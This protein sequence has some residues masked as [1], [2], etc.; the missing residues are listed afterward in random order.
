MSIEARRI[1]DD[2]IESFINVK[3]DAF[4]GSFGGHVEDER[5]LLEG[6][7]M[8]AAY[9][10]DRMV[11]AAGAFD[12]TVRIPG[13]DVPAAGVTRVGVLPTHR[14][15][16]ALTA[17]M[18]AQLDD[19][20]RH[21]RSIAM[22]FASEGGI[23][24]RFGYGLAS[25]QLEIRAER[26]SARWRNPAPPATFRIVDHDEAMKILPGL[27]E[28]ARTRAGMPARSSVWWELHRLR[29]DDPD[30]RR[31]GHLYRVIASDE[32]GRDIGYALYRAKL[33]WTDGVPAGRLAVLEAVGLTPPAEEALWRYLF[34]VDLIAAV[35][36]YHQPMDSPLLLLVAEPARLHGVVHDALWV[37]IVDVAQALS[38]RSYSGA[39]RIVVEVTDSMCPWNEGR[40]AVDTT[41]A[42]VAV[43]RT[44]EEPGLTTAVEGLGNLYLGGFTWRDLVRAGRA[45]ELRAGAAAAADSLFGAGPAPWCPEIF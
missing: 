44:D 43:G 28:S 39:G 26:N 1:R 15:K 32:S 5:R 2:E 7:L 8:H 27:Y 42:T 25:L 3:N 30:R 17:L 45:G 33:D 19:V 34:G 18:K 14:R 37:R 9:A 12:F 24:A 20:H 36:A 21:G 38:A 41:G 31:S 6:A 40:W 35:H 16:G 22:L 29:D 13:A 23:Y 11:G 10:G 4:A